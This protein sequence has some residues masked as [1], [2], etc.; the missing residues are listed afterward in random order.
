MCGCGVR[1]GPSG[2][3][4]HA[5]GFPPVPVRLPLPLQPTTAPPDWSRAT[6]DTA[7]YSRTRS[8]RCGP[9]DPGCDARVRTF[10]NDDCR[11]GSFP[12]PL[13]PHRPRPRGSW[14][15]IRRASPRPR[16]E[17]RQ[18]SER[19]DDSGGRTD[20]GLGWAV[21]LL[22]SKANE[23]RLPLEVA[24]ALPLSELEGACSLNMDC[25]LP[26]P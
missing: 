16:V 20:N 22:R 21:F 6:L 8:G 26:P 19:Q 1:V 4:G 2:L 15:Q 23:L 10:G 5:G 3:G 7:A 24:G 25:N 14:N 18:A 13:P 17:S 9:G 12:A 11:S